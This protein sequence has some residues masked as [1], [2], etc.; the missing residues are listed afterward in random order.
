MI[1]KY[2]SDMYL[3]NFS[4]YTYFSMFCYHETHAI[5]CVDIIQSRNNFVVTYS[6]S[7]QAGYPI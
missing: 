1:V 6:Q 7:A 5:F 2:Q 3:Y 4:I